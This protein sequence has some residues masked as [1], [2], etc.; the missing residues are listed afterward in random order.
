V[1]S[2]LVVLE[3]AAAVVL[4]AAAGLLVRSFLNVYGE[5]AG[6]ATENVLAFRLAP[7]NNR[8][9]EREDI[10]RLFADLTERI[11]T[12]SGVEDVAS[13]SYLPIEGGIWTNAFSF[14]D[15]PER[16]HSAHV[17]AVTPN[18]FDA[19]SIPVVVGRAFNRD[20]IEGAQEVAI[21]NE[22]FVR[23]FLPDGNP[24][25]RALTM[26]QPS[27]VIVG[28][29]ADTRFQGLEM[30][31]EP[32]FYTP[33][34][35]QS[36]WWLRRFQWIV[37]RTAGDP[38]AAFPR[39]REIVR[40]MDPTLP[41]SRVTTMREVVGQ[42]V[43]APRV[44][45]V[46]VGVFALVALILAGV[47]IAGVM[48]FSVASRARDFGVRVALGARPGGLMRRVLWQGLRLTAAG[49]VLG[50]AG[51]LVIGRLLSSLL[52]GVS[53]QDPA[54]LVGVIVVLTGTALLASY[55]PARRILGIDPVEALRSE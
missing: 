14:D 26:N 45:G 43:S 34:V 17:R 38:A 12:L 18:Y 23:R 42:N 52:Y 11:G 8:H 4:L 44:R 41:I 49:G 29:V 46:L 16:R 2:G 51:A 53:A 50:L 55:I 30:G 1:R 37:V 5:P 22:S 15:D 40:E 24:I 54:T 13:S 47:G 19:L 9:P 10:S 48:A 6:F 20:D 31:S 39:I 32:E 21:V 35:Q 7:S 28:V 3:M 36:Q 27:R 25:G 33:H